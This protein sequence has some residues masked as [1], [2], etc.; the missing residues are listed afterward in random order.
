MNVTNTKVDGRVDELD[1]LKDT[2]R[3]VG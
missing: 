1:K 3:K 2:R